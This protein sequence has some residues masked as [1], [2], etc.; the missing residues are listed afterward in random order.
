MIYCHDAIELHRMAQ[1]STDINRKGLGTQI[2]NYYLFHGL[3]GH[4]ILPQMR[5][6]VQ[7]AAP[8]RRHRG[9]STIR[10]PGSF[11]QTN[12]AARLLPGPGFSRVFPPALLQSAAQTY[13]EPS[14]EQES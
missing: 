9:I 10:T 3:W 11:V 14:I 12:V 8:W 2:R 1:L 4:V 13:F 7:R 6:T 5:T